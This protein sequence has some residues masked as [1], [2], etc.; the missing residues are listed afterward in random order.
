MNIKILASLLAIG[1]TA[2]AIGGAFTG[3]FFSDS[4]TSNHNT[5][6]SGTLNLQLSNDNTTW[7]DNVSMTINASNMAPGNLAGPKMFCLRN[8]GTVN[9]TVT[10]NTSYFNSSSSTT[11]SDAILFA[12]FLIVNKSVI[13]SSIVNVAPYWAQQIID[14][15]NGGNAANA[16]TA[17]EVVPFTNPDAGAPNYL[18][19]I[20]G[21]QFITLHFW[22]SYTNQVD[23]PFQP[24]VPVCENITVQFYDNG[25]NQNAVQNKTLTVLIN[26][27]M[28]QAN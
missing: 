5:F 21:L 25:L 4:A 1:L 14:Q 24:N 19:T 13:L 7:S 9:G 6:S 20:Y 17:G 26:G 15:H 3:A 23:I 18:P 12:K 28:I 10:V 27:Y 8:N 2:I 16:V 22:P 11:A